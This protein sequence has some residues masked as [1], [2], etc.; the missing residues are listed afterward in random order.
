MHVETKPFK[1]NVIYEL[2]SSTIGI[3][4]HNQTRNN[5]KSITNYLGTNY[6]RSGEGV[7]ADNIIRVHEILV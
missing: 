7:M 2:N 1:E 5:I 3:Q 6:L 4:S